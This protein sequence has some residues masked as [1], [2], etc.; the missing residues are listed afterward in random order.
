MP[1]SFESRQSWATKCAKHWQSSAAFWS[2]NGQR[3]HAYHAQT[4]HAD[5]INEILN[6]RP[7]HTEF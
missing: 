3:S 6:C 4:R 1:I 2:R 7:Y 5:Y